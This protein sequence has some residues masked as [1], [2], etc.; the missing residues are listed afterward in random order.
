MSHR[1]VLRLAAATLAVLFLPAAAR[2]QVVGIFTWQLQPYCNAV[3]LTLTGAPGGVWTLDGSDDQCG[4]SN[5]G[6][7]VGVATFNGTTVALNFSV[8]TAPSA[9]PVHVSALVSPA[10]GSGTWSDSAGNSGTF[11]F[12]ASTPN[13]PP[14]PS[15]PSGLPPGVITTTE[16]AAG[17]VGGSDINRAEVQA[18]VTGTCPAGQ[19]MSGIASDGSVTCM[20]PPGLVYVGSFTTGATTPIGTTTPPPAPFNYTATFNLTPGRYYVSG[21]LTARNSGASA[22]FAS[23]QLYSNETPVGNLSVETL[24]VV[25]GHG[26][27]AVAN[28]F[29]LATGGQTTISFRCVANVAGANYWFAN[30]TVFKVN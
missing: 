15:P 30:L 4:A 18:R 26:N 9:R 5:R 25:P 3:T 10:N 12:G 23:C 20:T 13:L 21:D 1:L 2:A 22:I 19:A 8:V 17:A 14:R 6:S 28:T 11:A 16:I 29:Q 24:P 27:F 7:A